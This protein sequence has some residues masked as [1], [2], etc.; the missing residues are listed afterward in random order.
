MHF[1]KKHIQEI[2]GQYIKENQEE[3]EIVK[4]GIQLKHSLTKD[5]LASI[6]N[7]EMRG[8]YEIP[9][10]LSNMLLLE[11]EEEELLWLKTKQGGFWFAKEFKVFALPTNI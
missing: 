1:T 8:L 5:D 4:K 7:S 11:L 10:T 3:F 6:E 9:E 2:V